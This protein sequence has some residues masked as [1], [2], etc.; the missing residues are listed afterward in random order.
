[1]K[2]YLQSV[3]VALTITAIPAYAEFTPSL[4]EQK[5]M[6]KEMQELQ[7]E[8]M[9]QIEYDLKNQFPA[10]MVKQHQMIMDSLPGDQ[11]IKK[12]VKQDSKNNNERT[13]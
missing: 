10:E 2:A 4:S 7:Q 1:M 12:T 9:Q 11:M 6:Q 8:A 13:L 5:E 3:I